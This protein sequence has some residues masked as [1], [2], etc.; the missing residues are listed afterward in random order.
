MKKEDIPYFGSI[1]N[2]GPNLSALFFPERGVELE[3]VIVP[4][5]TLVQIFVD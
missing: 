2:S 1:A 4:E 5:I 3:F